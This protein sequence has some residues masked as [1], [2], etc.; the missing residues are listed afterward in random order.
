MRLE[1]LAAKQCA[2][3]LTGETKI[4]ANGPLCPGLEQKLTSDDTNATLCY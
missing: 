2:A 3:D 1:T 4:N